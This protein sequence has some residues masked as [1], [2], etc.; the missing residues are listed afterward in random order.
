MRNEPKAKRRATH[1]PVPAKR[2]HPDD[3]TD[4]SGEPKSPPIVEVEQ[5]ERS[6]AP[7]EAE[8]A[9]RAP[10]LALREPGSGALGV[11]PIEALTYRV[12]SSESAPLSLRLAHE[13]VS[14]EHA[15]LSFDGRRFQLRDLSSKDGTRIAADELEPGAAQQ[16]VG[17]DVVHSIG[18]LEGLFA[19]EHD[20]AGRSPR[21]GLYERALALLAEQGQLE[22]HALAHALA[23]DAHPGLL[24]VGE[25]GVLAPREWCE[26][27]QLARILLERED[28]RRAGVSFARRVG[29]G[30]AL[31]SVVA[32]LLWLL[33][34]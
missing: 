15:E 7:R 12:G 5:R 10:R 27:L 32:A 2:F 33:L 26:A 29:A 6:L 16:L 18:W 8:L 19:V 14:G 13:S 23:D 34:R 21:E 28:K 9:A 11:H 4:D 17:C 20:N 1:P 25:L 22:S 31:L 24:L 3:L 30:V